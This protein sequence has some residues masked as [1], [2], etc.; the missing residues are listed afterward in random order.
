MIPGHLYFR[1]KNKRTYR[2]RFNKS[3]IGSLLNLF[4]L[5]SLCSFV[6]ND[7]LYQ[8]LSQISLLF[9]KRYPNFYQFSP[10]DRIG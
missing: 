9:V 2:L 7:L 1:H 8:P 3:L 10:V 6:L 4:N 5:L